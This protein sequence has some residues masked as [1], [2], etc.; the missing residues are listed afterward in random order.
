VRAFGAPSATLA[1]AGLVLA[2]EP[3]ALNI[4]SPISALAKVAPPAPREAAPAKATFRAPP[5]RAGGA[6]KAESCVRPAVFDR[7]GDGT[8]EVQVGVPQVNFPPGA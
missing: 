4:L 8:Q 7:P 3:R 5:S 2:R 1:I 6:A